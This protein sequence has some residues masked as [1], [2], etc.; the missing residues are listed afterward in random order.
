MD[1]QKLARFFESELAREMLSSDRVFR[2]KRFMI[3]YPAA[4]FTEKD[5]DLL[6]DETLLVQGV[7]DCAFFNSRG[8]LILVDYKTDWFSPS[9]PRTYVE[10]IL[11]ARHSR[12]LGYYAYACE[13]LF[14]V[15]P[16]HTYVYAFALDDTVEIDT[17]R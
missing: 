9:A 2:E 1:R 5:K 15:K 12:Q 7:I 4:L 16:A 8:E 6:K 13:T 3:R 11:R 17:N 10:K 14:G